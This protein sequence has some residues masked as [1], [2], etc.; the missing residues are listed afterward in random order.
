[1]FFGTKEKIE[2]KVAGMTCGHCET[3]VKQA[4]GSLPGVKRVFASFAEGKVTIEPDQ[5]GTIDRQQ[6]KEMIA[7]LGYQVV[8]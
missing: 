1:M 7:A 4:V 3:R 2:L 8:D 6:A 5:S